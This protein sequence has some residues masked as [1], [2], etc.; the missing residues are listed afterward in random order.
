MTYPTGEGWRTS[1]Y[2]TLA[3]VRTEEGPMIDGPVPNRIGVDR[4]MLAQ[5]VPAFGS[6][7]EATGTLI[8]LGHHYQLIGVDGTDVVVF[9]RCPA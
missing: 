9:D 6:W 4:S 8:I 3:I 2:E 5:M 1:G 7:T